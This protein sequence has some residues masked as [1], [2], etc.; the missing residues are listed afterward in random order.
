MDE[1][2]LEQIEYFTIQLQLQ[3]RNAGF[4]ASGL[5][6]ID[7]TLLTEVHGEFCIFYC[8]CY[9]IF[10]RRLLVLFQYILLLWWALQLLIPILQYFTEAMF[11]KTVRF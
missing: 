2:V 4:S 6:N 10:S 5:F 8:T 3:I 11:Q 1:D 7:R 9:F